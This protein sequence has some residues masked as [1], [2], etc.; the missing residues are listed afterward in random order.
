MVVAEHWT[1]ERRCAV[2]RVVRSRFTAALLQ[3]GRLRPVNPEN[4]QMIPPSTDR[5]WVTSV[6]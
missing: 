5:R 1:I 6:R 4:L 3:T 2:S